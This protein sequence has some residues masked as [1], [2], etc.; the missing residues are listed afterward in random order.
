MQEYSD[1]IAKATVEQKAILILEMLRDLQSKFPN[2]H[3]SFNCA[4]LSDR[5]RKEISQ[6]SVVN[7]SAPVEVIEQFLET[8]TNF[9]EDQVQRMHLLNTGKILVACLNDREQN[10]AFV[11]L[12]RFSQCY[13]VEHLHVQQGKNYLVLQS[14]NSGTT[15]GYES[16]R[17]VL[18]FNRQLM[19]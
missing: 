3:F 16:E 7:Q 13:V 18:L 17:F 4:L 5:T 9:K 10:V 15:P 14:M 2:F 8:L 6:V 1:H 12:V 19:N 11:D